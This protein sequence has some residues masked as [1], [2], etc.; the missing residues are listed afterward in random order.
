MIV[1]AEQVFFSLGYDNTR[2]EDIA[3][4]AGRSK[5]TLYTYFESKENLYMAITYRAF[6]ALLDNYYETL[7]NAQ[8]K[9]GLGIVLDFFYSYITFSEK[10]YHYQQLLLEYL[11]FIRSVSGEGQEVKLTPP[12][13]KSLWFKKVRDIHNLPISIII[14]II[15]E[16]QKD[17]SITNKSQ[18]EELF[19]T[20]FAI[21]IGYTKLSNSSESQRN[22]L[23]KVSL[24]NWKSQIRDLIENILVLS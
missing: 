2:M 10:H 9:S 12:L 1:V 19:L 6:Q 20:I 5:S 14:P 4:Q 3:I 11:T 13:K 23:F 18:P 21:L 15:K 16:G 8:E 24:E 17:G 22:T 7:N